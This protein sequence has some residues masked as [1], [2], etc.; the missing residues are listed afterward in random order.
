MDIVFWFFMGLIAFSLAAVVI[1][2]NGG[3]G[4]GTMFV[5]AVIIFLIFGLSLAFP[6]VT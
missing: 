4:V 6:V 2:L 1:S 5:I 3:N